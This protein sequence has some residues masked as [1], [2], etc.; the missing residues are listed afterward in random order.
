[1]CELVTEREAK[2]VAAMAESPRG[3]GWSGGIVVRLNAREG[4]MCVCVVGKIKKV[5]ALKL[6]NSFKTKTDDRQFRLII[7]S[8]GSN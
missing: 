7:F 2:R 3:W 1:M 4:E 8:I 5:R 6:Q